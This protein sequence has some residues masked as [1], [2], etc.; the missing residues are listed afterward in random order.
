M[1]PKKASKKPAKQ[2]KTT[3][4]MGSK[5]PSLSP[6]ISKPRS[7]RSKQIEDDEED[8]PSQGHLSSHLNTQSLSQSSL[9]GRKNRLN[10]ILTTQ[11][12]K[13][14]TTKAKRDRSS[15][16]EEDDGFIYKRSQTDESAGKKK[17]S[18]P[19]LQLNE[20]LKQ[21][22]RDSDDLELMDIQPKKGSHY[23]QKGIHSNQP[24]IGNHHNQ[25]KK[26]HNFLDESSLQLSSPVKNNSDDYNYDEYIEEVSH[27]KITLN[28][29]GRPG[30]KRRSSYHNRGKRVLSIGNGFEGE[31][32]HDVP[33]S[34]YY[35]L[36]D[37][38]L[39]EP[40]RMRQLMVW[41]FK[42]KLDQED[43]KKSASS[44]DQTVLNI[45]KVIKEE[46][47]RDLIEKQISISWYSN[48]TID[49][50][51]PG[52][53][54]TVPNPLNITNKK[55]I[56]LYSGKLKSI[57]REKDQWKRSYERSIK[58]IRN[59]QTHE[60]F[61]HNVT[62]DDLQA[63]L[64][65]KGENS[66]SASIAQDVAALTT[67][68]ETIARTITKTLEPS[69]DKLYQASYQMDKASEV[70][71]TIHKTKFNHRMSSLLKEYMTR[72][73]TVRAVT[74]W[75]SPASKIDTRS[76]LRSITR[77][78]KFSPKPNYSIG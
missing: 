69:V 38:S 50:T 33:V 1:P 64:A 2:V 5:P 57:L 3:N 37:T 41:C 46:I 16:F 10:D 60:S 35:K 72:N 45:A 75:P 73:E 66:Y 34:D 30:Q 17:I 42:K 26:V 29:K 36:L 25:P 71:D 68:C 56:Q 55:N 18:T 44:E 54:I 11:P 48:N 19:I 59:I 70:V 13:P 28:E 12:P 32:H 15:M 8:F 24:K 31:P 67:E 39:P 27:H 43:K 63:Y 74:I 61:N 4:A 49:D 77:V 62:D 47:L 52:K 6:P 51:I 14:K 9:L 21:M 76:L 20:E 58:P 22:S 40:D 7:R 23:N 65:T 78:E 53:E